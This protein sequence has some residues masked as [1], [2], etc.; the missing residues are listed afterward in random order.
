MN[1][2]DQEFIKEL[3]IMHRQNLRFDIFTVKGAVNRLIEIRHKY[4]KEALFAYVDGFNAG[5]QQAMD[6]VQS[7]LNQFKEA[8]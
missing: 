2:E 5:H 7:K 1:Q 6:K 4:G 8:A 3:C